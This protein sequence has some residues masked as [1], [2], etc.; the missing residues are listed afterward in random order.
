MKNQYVSKKKQ[1][2]LRCS[3]A[4]IKNKWNDLPFEKHK[5]YSK[6]PD[7]TQ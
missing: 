2:C 7:R 1:E 6:L 5:F 4:S 3:I